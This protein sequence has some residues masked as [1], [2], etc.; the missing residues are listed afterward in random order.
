MTDSRRVEVVGHGG[1]GAYFP[2]NSRP[3]IERALE[4]GVDR[5][6]CDVQRTSDGVLVLGHDEH[7]V[8]DGLKLAL[9]GLGLDTLRMG[10]ADLLTLDEHLELVGDRADHLLDMKAPGYERELADAIRRH[11]IAERTIVSS[12]YALGL[13]RLRST[14]PGLTTGLSS[15]H[16]ASGVPVE[17]VRELLGRSSASR[18]QGR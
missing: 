7:V 12:T 15:G 9:R 3:A 2:G 18:R 5:I 4:F 11:G 10:V 6:E 8:V 13:R 17:R 16:L 1:A 14:V